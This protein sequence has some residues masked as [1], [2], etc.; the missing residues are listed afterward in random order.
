MPLEWRI[1]GARVGESLPYSIAQGR[2]RK[3][4]ALLHAPRAASS[5]EGHSPTRLDTG[6]SLVR[7]TNLFQSLVKAFSIPA[8]NISKGA[9]SKNRKWSG[10]AEQAEQIFCWLADG[11]CGRLVRK[12]SNSVTSDGKE[13]HIIMKFY[14]V[15]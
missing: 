2:V 1:G 15:R 4:A 5:G 11:I 14:H 3:L 12:G 7:F 10:D 13:T 6:F 8:D 9:E